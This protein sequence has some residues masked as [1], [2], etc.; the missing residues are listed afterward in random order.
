MLIDREPSAIACQVL[1]SSKTIQDNTLRMQAKVDA[2][3]AADMHELISS[4]GVE[5][6][7]APVGLGWQ[8]VNDLVD[9]AKTGSAK[10]P[11]ST[12]AVLAQSQRAEQSASVALDATPVR[13]P[14]GRSGICCAPLSCC[15][16]KEKLTH[17]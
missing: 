12:V 13:A 5:A 2:G 14:A 7:L 8:V 11:S 17:L 6:F 9:A 10:A 15:D 4:T 1:D 16:H 3:Y